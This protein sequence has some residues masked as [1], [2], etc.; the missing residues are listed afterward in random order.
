MELLDDCYHLRWYPDAGE[1][2]PQKGAVD[3][4]TSL[5]DINEAYEE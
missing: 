2:L 3:S 5:F 1:F 4:V